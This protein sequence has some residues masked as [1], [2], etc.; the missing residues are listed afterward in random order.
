MRVNKRE[1]SKGS[2]QATSLALRRL[3]LAL[4][5]ANRQLFRVFA[6]RVGREAGVRAARD[7]A[8]D[9]DKQLL[10][11]VTVSIQSSTEA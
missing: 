3:L 8:I 2:V 1:T 10:H 4:T 7:I 9:S 5:L 6:R 11:L